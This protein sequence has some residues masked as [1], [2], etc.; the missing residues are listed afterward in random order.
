MNGEIAAEHIIGIASGVHPLGAVW[1]DGQA[2]VQIAEVMNVVS[3]DIACQPKRTHTLELRQICQLHMF[4]RMAVVCIGGFQQGR[5]IGLD[6]QFRCGIAIGV[7]MRLD[8]CLVQGAHGLTEVIH[9]HVPYA[10]VFHL[11]VSRRLEHCRTALNGPIGKKLRPP[12]IQLRR[13]AFAQRN[14]ALRLERRIVAHGIHDRHITCRKR[15]I[16]CDL[17]EHG[18]LGIFQIREQISH[19]GHAAVARYLAIAF[20]G[21]T[22]REFAKI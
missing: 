9:L 4:Q 20:D 11:E 18:H 6:R 13:G 8:A 17:F 3:K 19:R 21:G 14:S 1:A 5:L 2:P 15:R 10:V 7:G 22:V 16:A 12:Q